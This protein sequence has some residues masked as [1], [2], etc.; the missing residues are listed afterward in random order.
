MNV[1]SSGS[2][3]NAGSERRKERTARNV[4]ENERETEKESV[5]AGEEADH[6]EVIHA[7]MTD[8]A[9][10]AVITIAGT[11]EGAQDLGVATMTVA[12]AAGAHVA[13]E[14][15]ADI[16][17]AARTGMAV[18]I[19]VAGIRSKA[20]TKTR[21]ETLGPSDQRTEIPGLSDRRTEIPGLNNRKTEI[22]GLNDRR[23]EIPG[24]N[25]R[26]TEI[27]VPNI[28]RIETPGP[29]DR[30]NQGLPRAAARAQRKRKKSEAR[31]L[32]SLMMAA[33]TLKVTLKKIE[34]PDWHLRWRFFSSLQLNQ[35]QWF[36]VC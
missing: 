20:G 33:C 28:Q 2:V 34:V 13:A 30:R 15:A 27:L 18:P 11:G 25:G 29:S 36:D 9:V 17:L 5:T 4:R 26:R 24:L 8:A 14:V 10:T 12:R 31:A 19:Q 1:R 3:R 21:I 16:V 23:T 6:V 7:V 32:P 35:D 22:P